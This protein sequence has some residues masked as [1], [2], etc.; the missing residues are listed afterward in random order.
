[1]GEGVEVNYSHCHISEVDLRFSNISFP[2]ECSLPW[3]CTV[4]IEHIS[5]LP[6]PSSSFVTQPGQI[7]F[8]S[9]D[10]KG[11]VFSLTTKRDTLPKSNSWP[12]TK[13]VGR[14]FAFW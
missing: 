4:P 14:L 7:C 10:E 1:M 3:H 5:I 13:V 12:L 8:I 2:W 9:W 11:V 6:W